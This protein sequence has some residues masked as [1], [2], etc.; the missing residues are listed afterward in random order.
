M[1]VLSHTGGAGSLGLRHRRVLTR[2]LSGAADRNI[3]FDDLRRLL[4][5]LGFAQRVRGSHHIFTRQGVVEIINL[6]P[7]EGG[8]AKPYQVRQV[9]D[10]IVKY[11]LAEEGK[12]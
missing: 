7:R 12:S 11:R 3:R 10:L 8:M 2:I 4:V 1:F 5:A 9:R 6:Q